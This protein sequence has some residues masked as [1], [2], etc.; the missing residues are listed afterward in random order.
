MEELVRAYIELR[1]Q[2]DLIKDRHKAELAEVTAV[3]DQVEDA[4]M[5]QLQELGVESVKTKAGT[6]F[7]S[8]WTSV[9]VTD[10]DALCEYVK[11]NDRFDLLE[12]RVNKTVALEIGEVPGTLAESGFQVNIRRS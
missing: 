1:D 4:L 9:K 2:R 12:R 11:T 5:H 3:L 8:K 6:A 7:K 10:F